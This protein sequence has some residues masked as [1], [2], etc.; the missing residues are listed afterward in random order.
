MGLEI[1]GI[2]WFKAGENNYA[3][4]GQESEPPKINMI[5]IKATGDTLI[6]ST[7]G[8]VKIDIHLEENY[9]EAKVKTK[10]GETINYRL[11][12]TTVDSMKDYLEALSRMAGDIMIAYTKETSPKVRNDLL[13]AHAAVLKELVG[14][15]LEK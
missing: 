5:I 6:S 15:K 7:R 3:V 14:L 9:A 10:T 12:D 8:D 1:P 2:V 13:K 4:K 11:G